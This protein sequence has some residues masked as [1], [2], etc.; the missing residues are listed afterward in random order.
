MPQR[1]K[2]KTTQLMPQ[3]RVILITLEYHPLKFGG[4]TVTAGASLRGA[5]ESPKQN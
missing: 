4:N 5:V 3:I 1:I 2:N